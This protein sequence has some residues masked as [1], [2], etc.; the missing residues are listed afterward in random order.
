MNLNNMNRLGGVCNQRTANNSPGNVD[1]DWDANPYLSDDASASEDDGFHLI[2]DVHTTDNV[3]SV[4]INNPLLI[5]Y[6]LKGSIIIQSN[7]SG[8]NSKIDL[9]LYP[10]SNLK[11]VDLVLVLEMLKSTNNLGDTNEAIILGLLASFLPENNEIKIYLSQTSSS[12]YH[13]QKLI[14]STHCHLQ[15]SSVH[16]IHMCSCKTVAYCGPNRLLIRCPKC[17]LRKDKL[18]DETCFFYYLPL[19]D[20][21]IRLLCSDLKN[22]FYYPELRNRGHV[23]YVE[24]NFDGSNW[25]AFEAQMNPINN[26]RLIGLQWC[27]D[28]ADA[29]EFSGKTFWPGCISILNFPLDLRSKMHVGMHVISLCDGNYLPLIYCIFTI[30]LLLIYCIF[31]VHLLFI[32][33]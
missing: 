14:K 18:D 22:L 15:K 19:K 28:G 11:L 17:N 30:C 27:W 26:E 4:I 21:L 20:R 10:G 24:D 25:K 16:K 33:P 7:I 2:G 12:I 3:E 32:Y 8:S 29:F 31:T 5:D 9:D 1:F 6:Y 23:D 13:F